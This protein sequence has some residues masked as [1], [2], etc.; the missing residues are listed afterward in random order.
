ML[1]TASPTGQ[2]VSQSSHA[3]DGNTW[4]LNRLPLRSG[5]LGTR[6]MVPF[7]VLKG[8]FKKM[9][10]SVGCWSLSGSKEPKRRG[11]AVPTF[12]FRFLSYPLFLFSELVFFLLLGI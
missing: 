5:E 2:S 10:Y 11:K 8:L 6:E 3:L 1:A 4:P 9:F 7:W 12:T